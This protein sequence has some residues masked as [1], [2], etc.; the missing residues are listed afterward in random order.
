VVHEEL[1]VVEFPLRGEWVA[2][3]TPAERIPSH[4]T[5]Q[6]GQRF[7]YD[8]MRIER[9]HPDWKFCR[10]PLWRYQLFG[11]PLR[12]CYGWGQP[13]HAPFDGVVIAASDGSPERRRLHFISD[14]A[15]MLS[16]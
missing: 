3:H 1:I 16:C 6:L 13:I 10:S 14:H 9:D 12:D 7:A 4:G 15:I 2:Y 11:V 5:D 8:F